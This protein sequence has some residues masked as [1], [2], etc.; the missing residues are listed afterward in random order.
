MGVRGERQGV[1]SRSGMGAAL[2][3]VPSPAERSAA[4]DGTRRRAG[5]AH[6]PGR[7]RARRASANW[8]PALA[9]DP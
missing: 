1:G 9:G 8:Q 5:A 3:R 4:G 2:R 7:R 6:A